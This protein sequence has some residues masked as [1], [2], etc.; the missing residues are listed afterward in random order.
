[1]VFP[2]RDWELGLE[3][4]SESELGLQFFKSSEEMER[5]FAIPLF[6]AKATVSSEIRVLP[7][8]PDTST[9]SQ[10]GNYTPQC[11]LFIPVRPA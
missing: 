5:R 7:A 9:V 6:I 4:E 8:R 10:S 3:L 1:M 2:S 11:G